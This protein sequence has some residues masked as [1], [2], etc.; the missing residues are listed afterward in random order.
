MTTQERKIHIGIDVS[1]ALLDVFN[2]DT[3]S[4]H[5][6]DNSTP[7]I[8][9][10]MSEL[11]KYNKNHI[12]F[13]LEATGGYEKLAAKTLVENGFSVAVINPRI[14]RDFAKASGKL[15]KT[16]KIDAKIIAAYAETMKPDS[17]FVFNENQAEIHELSTRRAQ[18]VAMIIAEKNRLDKVSSKIKKSILRTIKYLEKELAEI[19]KQLKS[20][21][22]A[23]ETFAQKQALLMSVKGIGEKTATA[24]IA[25]LPELGS[26]EERQITALAGLAPFNCDSG[27]MRGKRMIWGGRRTVRTAL[28][29]ATIAA[30]RSNSVI[31]TFYNRLVSAGKPKMVALTACMRKLI[32][33]TN[34]MIRHN[35]P[36]QEN[37]G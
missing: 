37:Y 34:A 32:I 22:I 14:I 5:Q 1:K 11:K 18:L 6:L 30:T 23:D 25:Y 29:M 13:T 35:Q 8:K 9:K 7:G 3:A 27:K 36:W 15:A 19:D 17:R 10:L 20:S 2:T 4:Y 24:L 21:V 31:K 12:L 26:L 33:I 28:Y 16:D